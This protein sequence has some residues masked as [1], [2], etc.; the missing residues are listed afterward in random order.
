MIDEEP[1]FGEPE[2]GLAY[3]VRPGVYG[4]ALDGA[5][6]VLVA[7]AGSRLA[8]PGGGIEPGETL[9]EALRREVAEETG[10]RIAIR[11]RVGFAIQHVFAADYGRHWAKHCTYVLIAVT[12]PPDGPTEHEARWLPVAEALAAL[13]DEADRWA[14]ARALAPRP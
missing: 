5:G 14:L 1:V 13:T 6:H 9:D 2:A 11:Q 10:Y 12:G 7:D 4:I 3:A 8:L